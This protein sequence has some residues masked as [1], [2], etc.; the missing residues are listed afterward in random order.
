MGLSV[1]AACLPTLAPIFRDLSAKDISERLGSFFTLRWRSAKDLTS[2]SETNIV[3][4]IGNENN[5]G[6]E[7][8]AMGNLK[9]Q[10]GEERGPTPE[11]DDQI[12]ITRRM[13]T[14]SLFDK[15]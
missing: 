6:V 14:H 5:Y 4:M 12:Y 11:M 1:I 3:R 2:V 7:T 15:V 13:S 9:R 8:V 10:A